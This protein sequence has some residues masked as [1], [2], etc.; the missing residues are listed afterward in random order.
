MKQLLCS[1]SAL[2]LCLLAGMSS[3]AQLH[4][5]SVPEGLEIHMSSELV[6][7]GINQMHSWEIRLSDLLGNPAEQA[8]IAITGGMPA[9]NHGL[10]TM[11]QITPTDTPGIYVLDGMR[12]HMPGEWE[13]LL[14]IEWQGQRYRVLF[15]LQL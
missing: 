8:S 1:V 4:A 9:H 14:Q 3:A 11:P 2:V 13:L 12:F 6:P 10:A 15:P 7:L 5:T